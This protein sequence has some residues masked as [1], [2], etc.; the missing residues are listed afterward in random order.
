MKHYIEIMTF[1]NV[2]EYNFWETLDSLFPDISVYTDF[3]ISSKY[4]KEIDT[5]VYY[6]KIIVEPNSDLKYDTIIDAYK[7][8]INDCK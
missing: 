7:E 4:V 6:I 3:K 2:G 5:Y 8:A 1:K